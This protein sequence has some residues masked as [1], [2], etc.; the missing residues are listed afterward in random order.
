MLEREDLRQVRSVIKDVLREEQLDKLPDL[1]GREHHKHRGTHGLT[2]QQIVDVPDYIDNRQFITI[3]NEEGDGMAFVDLLG[4]DHQIVV[5]KNP[6]DFALS[7][8]SQV[9]VYSAIEQP[10][11]RISNLSDTEL[12]P[13]LQFA[14]A[15]GDNVQFTIG[16]DDSDGNKLKF[17]NLS[18]LGTL[19]ETQGSYGEILVYFHGGDENIAYVDLADFTTDGVIYNGTAGSGDGQFANV[20]SITYDGAF[21]YVCDNTNSR[22]QKFDASSGV[23]VSKIAIN[24]PW[25]ICYWDGFIYTMNQ[26]AVAGHFNLY[27]IDAAAMTITATYEFDSGTANGEFSGPRGMATDGTYLYICDYSNNRIKKCS[28]AG[29]YVAKVGSYGTGNGQFNGPA[30]CEVDGTYLYVCDY[31]NKRIQVFDVAAMSYQ[32]QHPTQTVGPAAGS[33]GSISINDLY[34]YVGCNNAVPYNGYIEKY[35][36]ATRSYQATYDCVPLASRPDVMWSGE[37][38]KFA[39][40][41]IKYGDLV[42]LHQ[43]GNFLDVWPIARFVDDVRL[44]EDGDLAAGDYVGLKAPA[45]VTASY[46]ITFPAAVPG[47]AG[48]FAVGSSGVISW[49]QALGTTDSPTFVMMTL[50]QGAADDRILALKSSDVAHGMTALQETDTYAAFLKS[51]GASGG[52]KIRGLTEASD[53]IVLAGSYTTDNTTKST[54]GHAAVEVWGQKK[55][56]TGVI[57]PGANAN[58]FG[59]MKYTAP[60]ALWLCDVEGDTWQAGTV[61]G[62]Q[63]IFNIAIG[64]APLTIT[65]TTVVTNL[66]ADLLDG[67]HSSAFAAAGHDHSGVYSPVGHTHALDD[68]SDVNAGAPNDNDVLSWDTA[69]GKWIAVVPSGGGGAFLDLTDVTEADYSGHANQ[70]VKVNAAE[71]GLEFIASSAAAHALGSASHTDV[72]AAAPSDDDILRFDTA[73]GKWKNEALPAASN[74]N[75]LSAT[76]SDTLADSVVR[77]DI[78]VGNSTP[79]WSR[80]AKG[81]AGYAL[82]MGASDPAWAA[83]PAVGGPCVI[84]NETFDGLSLANIN[85][86]GSYTYFASWAVTLSGT[87][88]AVVTDLGSGNYCLRLTGDAG[89]ASCYAYLVAAAALPLDLSHGVRVRIKIRT[90]DVSMGS[91]GFAIGTGTATPLC[92]VYFRNSTTD[93]LTF[94]NGTANTKILDVSDNTW[95][96]IDVVIFKITT[97]AIDCM[98][99]VDGVYQA[100]YACGAHAA[101]APW[102]YFSIYDNPAAAG[103]DSYIDVDYIKLGHAFVFPA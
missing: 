77:G 74:H 61:T 37:I 30:D 58:I 70:F 12:D 20:N 62:T 27:K 42:V 4:T 88:A 65:S 1:F 73:S 82:I 80:L 9:H 35:D 46:S 57:D 66:N 75:L 69:S 72:D 78:M 36:I 97:T 19:A 34:Y 55:S 103:S 24:R 16:V 68:L 100:S 59:I 21:I 11:V 41:G 10:Y 99:W 14:L 91:K 13:V 60:A 67:S 5:T 81:A 45:T 40:A 29:V 32:A 85:G 92:Q 22:I 2:F 7:L 64:T 98:V 26:I 25:G 71:N 56:G 15:A 49:G 101:A 18:A 93:Q 28:M 79:K 90:D 33:P 51:T 87:S 8:D 76:H 63:G 23:F 17:A 6:A 44:I 39:S 84:L 54:S 43:D 95:Y 31:A 96:I 102:L 86:Q 52:L 48:H 47:A 38:A 89:A 83:L 53:A 94:W 50:N 3:V